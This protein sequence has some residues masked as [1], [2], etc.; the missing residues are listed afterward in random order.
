M[1]STTDAQITIGSA[2]FMV[3]AGWSEVK[4]ND[5]RITLLTFRAL[6]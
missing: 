3:P 2:N 5:E 6:G 4:S 1:Q